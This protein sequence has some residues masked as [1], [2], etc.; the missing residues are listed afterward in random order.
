V[1]CIREKRRSTELYSVD[2]EVKCYLGANAEER[3]MLNQIIRNCERSWAGLV[4]V[5]ILNHSRI[6]YTRS[7]NFRVLH[8]VGN[9]LTT[10]AT[11][12]IVCRRVIFRRRSYEYRLKQQVFKNCSKILHCSFNF[13]SSATYKVS[14][15]LHRRGTTLLP[16]VVC[17]LATR[18][19][20][21]LSSEPA[22]S[23][24][25]SNIRLLWCSFLTQMRLSSHIMN[26][27]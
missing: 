7:M 11:T 10:Q 18:Q 1:V 24:T 26:V 23:L 12:V 3:M 9:S 2:L 19:T 25:N 16:A 6:P 17:Q 27:A 14:D 21:W 13:L 15:N 20:C 8:D 5:K 4:W 22:S